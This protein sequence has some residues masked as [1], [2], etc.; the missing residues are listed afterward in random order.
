MVISRTLAVAKSSSL[1]VISAVYRLPG[2]PGKREQ[3]SSARA[4]VCLFSGKGDPSALMADL[5]ACGGLGPQSDLSKAS[6]SAPRA[7][8]ATIMKAPL[9]MVI[10][11]TPKARTAR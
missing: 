10:F 8:P 2:R 9:A 3:A 1:A 6:P 11:V 5:W 7:S 4:E